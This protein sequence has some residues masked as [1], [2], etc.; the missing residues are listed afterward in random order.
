MFALVTD[1]MVD[2]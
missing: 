2:S 1:E